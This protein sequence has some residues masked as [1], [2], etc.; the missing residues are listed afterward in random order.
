MNGEFSITNA[1]D[2]SKTRKIELLD[3][4]EIEE[5]TEKKTLSI[6]T[7]Q[8]EKEKEINVIP[9]RGL[10]AYKDRVKE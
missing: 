9:L 5:K 7:P 1:G 6:S 4:F 2:I 3:H 8:I 10:A